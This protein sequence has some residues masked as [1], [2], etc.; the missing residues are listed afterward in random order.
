M[1]EIFRPKAIIVFLS[2]IIFIQALV[3]MRLLPKKEMDLAPVAKGK[4]AIVLDDWGYNLNNLDFIEDIEYPLSISVLPNLAYSQTVAR[5]VK[6][7]NKELILHLPL[8]PESKKGYIGLEKDTITTQM[9]ESQ[10][11]DI[12]LKALDNF[13]EVKGVSNHMGSK[14]TQC[15]R[16]MGI[17]FGE[18]KKR[19]LYFLDSLVSPNSVCSDIA[20]GRGTKFT[21]R[22]IFLDNQNDPAYIKGQLEELKE[23]SSLQGYAV[24]IGHD[25]KNTLLVLAE[26]MPEIERE[27]YEF[28]FISQVL[29]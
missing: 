13:P 22:D 20:R 15:R 11:K 24:G 21:K 5:K 18:L 26:Q 17:I 6:Q 14:A 2:L 8:E 4:I 9:K 23:I 16:T 25:R 3:I 1:K 19:N 28:V 27:G 29:K 7:E 10:I 12:L